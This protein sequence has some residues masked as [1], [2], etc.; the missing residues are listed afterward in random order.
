MMILMKVCAPSSHLETYEAFANFV[1]C[2]HS[3]L[4][5][6]EK[7]VDQPD[8]LWDLSI[9]KDVNITIHQSILDIIHDNQ[10]PFCKRGVLQSSLD[11]E[12]YL[13]TDNS[14]PICCR[15]P[16]YGFHESKIMTKPIADLEASGLITNSEEYL[17]SLL[18]LA[19]KTYQESCNNINAFMWR[20]YV[21]CR[22]VN[23]IIIG[24]KFSTF[25]CAD[26]I[27]DLSDLCGSLLMIP[28]V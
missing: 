22:P 7:Y 17:G 8:L 27:D 13:D 2:C 28:L 19:E 1:P 18:L 6:W 11:F 10:D 23:R 24:F 12:L 3:S 9:G 26:S 21:N 20:F 15:Q 4:I 14:P 16:M 5:F 25:R